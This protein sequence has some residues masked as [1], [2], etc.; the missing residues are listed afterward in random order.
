MSKGNATGFRSLIYIDLFGGIWSW[1]L[2]SSHLES[3]SRP[4][5]GYGCHYRAIVANKYMRIIHAVTPYPAKLLRIP[6]QT[7]DIFRDSLHT[8]HD[9]NIPLHQ[10]PHIAPSALIFP[11]LLFHDSLSRNESGRCVSEMVLV[12]LQR[13]ECL[14]VIYGRKRLVPQHAKLQ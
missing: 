5:T 8:P 13:I 6:F 4:V 2:G 11:Q 9:L 1:T 14:R 10:T 3:I 7:L 12:I